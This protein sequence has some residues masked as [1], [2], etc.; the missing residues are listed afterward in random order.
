METR[1]IELLDRIAT[2]HPE[3]DAPETFPSGQ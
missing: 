3:G 2:K 1:A